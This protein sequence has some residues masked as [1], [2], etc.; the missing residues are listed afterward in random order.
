[1]SNAK[2]ELLAGLEVKGEVTP[3]FENILTPEAL[4][5]LAELHRKFDAR[6]HELLKKREAR[7]A[8]ID[9]GNM[10][11][12]LE[13]TKHIREDKSWKVAPI[14]QDLQDRRVEIT[15]PVERKMMINALNSGANV[16]M[17]DFE[18]S[19]SPTWEN[20]VQGQINCYDAIRRTIT[21]HDAKKGKDYQLGEDVAVLLAR[22]RGWHLNE[23]NL[24][25]DG[26]PMSGGLFDFGLYMFHNA[27]ELLKRGSGPY[28]YLPKLESHLEARLWNDA[29][30]FAQDYL[31]IP[32]GSIK[33]T[34][35][36]ETIMAS[37]EIEEILY[38]LKE[39][40]AG[41]NAGRWDYIFSAIKKFRNVV[42]QPLPDRGQITMT[43]PFMKAYT[44]LLVE[45]CHRR[46]AHAMGGMSAFI[47]TRH[48]E[49]VN[50][51][52][53]EKVRKDKER[54]A[55]D[56]FDG[57]WVAHPDLVKVAKDVFD[58]KFGDKPNQ[59]D[60]LREDVDLAKMEKELTN[61]NIEGGKITDAG[62]RMNFNV[63]IRY[64]ASWLNGVGAAAIFNLMEDAATAEIS[65][66]Q[67]W[68]WLNHPNAKLEDGSEITEEYLRKC[69]EEEYQSIKDEAA[70]YPNYDFENS[71]FPKA[72]ELMEEL[73]FTKEYKDFLTT[74]AYHL[75]S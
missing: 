75:I 24:L 25:I 44:E 60:R 74:E 27:K 64:I 63:G 13:E 62:V 70:Q 54:E 10:P 59:K 8:E 51:Q 55:N 71:T 49:E 23:K 50:K 36:L 42:E 33:A 73:V 66:T 20:A 22:P 14:P 11:T 4:A 34:V 40:M 6:R 7:Q 56:G 30:V 46:G 38:E 53:F 72:K 43:V 65:R 3:E 67:L 16:F 45:A 52:A 17:T 2:S 12:R 47:P 28:F 69:M 58:A 29:F 15:G 48:D 9:K 32:Q 19:N 39:H 5:F 68:Q 57:S 61:F 37:F 26:K 35:L 41:I 21:F 1:M 31:D 18:D